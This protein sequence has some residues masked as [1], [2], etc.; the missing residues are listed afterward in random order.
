MILELLLV[1]GPS[2]IGVIFAAFDHLIL[3]LVA[4]IG[5]CAICCFVVK[6]VTEPDS[7]DQQ[8]M[9]HHFTEFVLII[10]FIYV[11]LG[12]GILF[13]ISLIYGFIALASVVLCY[14]GFVSVAKCIE[15]VQMMAWGLPSLS[16]DLP[17][18]LAVLA[19][20]V[21]VVL[22][23]ILLFVTQPVNGA[24]LMGVMLGVSCLISVAGFF[25]SHLKRRLPPS[26]T[27]SIPPRALPVIAL[28]TMSVLPVILLTSLAILLFNIHVVVGVAGVVLFVAKSFPLLLTSVTIKRLLFV[29]YSCPC[30]MLGVISFLISSH[31]LQTTSSSL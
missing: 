6:K 26:S 19:L 4:A 31:A 10:T 11:A 23:A 2:L 13:T 8:S 7:I 20:P 5:I 14:V 3:S 22:D 28:I 25:H 24:V 17:L 18:T 21:V 1:V 30:T 16:S 9:E 12:L 27:Q 29:L 15:G